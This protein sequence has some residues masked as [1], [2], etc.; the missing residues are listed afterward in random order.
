[1]P[2]LGIL[3]MQSVR[4]EEGKRK[5]EATSGAVSP[6]R[7]AFE[8]A[9]REAGR[10]PGI[11]ADASAGEWDGAQFEARIEKRLGSRTKDLARWAELGRNGWELVAVNGKHAFFRRTHRP[12]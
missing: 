1:M 4:F 5:R 8:E 2:K 9:R 3:V 7:A 6:F 11:Q 10:Q 12:G